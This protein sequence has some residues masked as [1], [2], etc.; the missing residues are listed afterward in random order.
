MIGRETPTTGQAADGNRAWLPPWPVL[1][2]VV[3]WLAA[4]AWIGGL[5][6]GRVNGVAAPVLDLAFFQQV[7]WNVG[8]HGEWTSMY[9]AGSFL[10]LHFSPVLIVPAVI[11]R[12]IWQDVRVLNLIHA[13]LVA[14]LVPSTFLFLR[15]AF[16]PSRSAALLAAGVAIG[17]PVWGATQDVIRADFHP[18]TAGVVLA[19]LAGWAGLS[20]RP[21]TMWILAAVALLTRE[22]A[23]YAVG[24]IGLVVAARGRG[25]A[26]RR[27]R[28]LAIV[29]IVWAI[30]VFGV[31]MPAIRGG[32]VLNTNSYYAWLGGGLEVL[33]APF[34]KT[35]RVIAA[36]TR[37]APWF[38]V[39]G[40]VV[41]V[42]ALPLLRPRWALLMLP[43]LIALLLSSHS[44]QANVLLQYPLILEVP[45]LAATAFGG[46]RALAW[47]ARRR[48]R[49]RSRD[50]GPTAS[51]RVA[52]AAGSRRAGMPVVAV[53][54]VGIAVAGGW[55]QGLLPPFSAAD[56][57]FAR[58]DV[59]I[60]AMVRMAA[61]V[62]V[63]ALLIAD[64]GMVATL[65]SRPQVIR[66][67]GFPSPPRSAYVLADRQA[68]PPSG[69]TADRHAT[70]VAGLMAGSRPI[71]AD[72]GR[73]V[74][75]GPEPGG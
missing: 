2:T 50:S 28:W 21:R 26:R 65:S 72:D 36:L 22:D 34:T 37:P 47:V 55:A 58:H 45:L 10:G 32:V 51:L 40:M 73:F 31:I 35:Q 33:N 4:T 63:D 1:A 64:E 15:S 19:L 42:G 14:A 74:L 13:A 70:I 54:I 30:L 24:V 18:E 11:E 3:A 23:A 75:W 48:R 29:A 20:G 39:L 17:I 62:P 8:Q 66:M 60:D 44:W 61:R 5:L 27:G 52:G 59:A 71:I 43:P 69:L 9:H 16:R 57:A 56:P 38:V 41:S 6:V 49:R 46:R 67:A 68:W 12:F 7:V 25:R 53:A